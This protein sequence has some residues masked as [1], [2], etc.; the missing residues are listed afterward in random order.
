MNYKLIIRIIGMI[1]TLEAFFMLVPSLICYFDDDI[2]AG[3]AFAATMLAL[4]LIGVLAIFFTRNRKNDLYAHEGFAV[5]GL[6][7][8]LM[9]VFGALPFALSG[10]IPNYIDALFETISGFTTT[11]ASILSDVESLPRGILYWRSFTNWLGGM[12]VLV[13]LMSL[14]PAVSKNSG[15]N[16]YIMSAESSGPSVGKL[17]PKLRDT[18]LIT[19]GLYIAMTITCCI[20]LLIGKMP[21]LDALC[22]S[23]STAGTGGFGLK[24]DSFASYSPFIQNTITV[25]MLLFSVSFNIYG[26][27]AFRRFKDALKDEELHVFLIIVLSAI[28]L[29]SVDTRGIFSSWSETIRHSAFQVSTVIS[30]CGF[31]SCDFDLWPSFS[32]GILMVLMLFGGCAG[33][34]AGG[35]KIS[36]VLII[37]KNLLRETSKALHP[38][39]I[40]IVKLN[41]K[42]VNEQVVQ[43]TMAYI[44]AYCLILIV[45]FI[46]VS[47]DGYSIGTNVSATIACLNNIGPGFEAVGPTRNFSGFSYLSKIVFSIEMLLGRLEIF[48]IIMLANKSAWSRK[49]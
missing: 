10:A 45:S 23:F 22:L 14:I 18:L 33:S 2:V 35:L 3:N 44:A 32:K 27:L 11:G 34:T 25:F 20:V 8:I 38:H 48:P 36:R 47:L 15:S 46:I 26:L 4:I 19:Y 5:T 9:S 31:A 13:F 24:N 6:S 39:K 16:M 37:L 1:M 17:T 41:K 40:Q 12:G 43:M 49:L 30:T 42:P 28:I 21:F 29:I 7:W